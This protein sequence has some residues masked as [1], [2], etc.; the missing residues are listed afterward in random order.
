MDWPFNLPWG[1][2]INARLLAFNAYGESDV[3]PY[4]NG[5]IITT[6]PDAPVGLED[7]IALRTPTSL[8]FRWQEGAKNGGAT[9]TSYRV[10]FDQAVG[11]WQVLAEQVR[12]T[13]YTV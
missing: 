11:V 8:S 1:S 10:S 2:S 7:L 12:G 3:S 13:Q 5:A 6:N 9:V 4:G